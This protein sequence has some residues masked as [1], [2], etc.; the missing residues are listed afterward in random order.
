MPRITLAHWHDGRAPGEEVDVDEDALKDLVRDGR[1]SAVHDAKALEAPL[2]EE[3]AAPD[4]VSA[5][6]LEDETAAVPPPTAEVTSPAAPS[7]RKGR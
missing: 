6:A 1:V 4:A 3:N 7:R 5:S 2:A